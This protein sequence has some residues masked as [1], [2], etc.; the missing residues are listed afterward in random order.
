MSS[1][2]S[3]PQY[4]RSLAELEGDPT[5]QEY[6]ER[7]FRS[8]TEQKELDGKGR[9]RFMQLM[10]ASFALS[11]CYPAEKLAPDTKRADGVIPGVPRHFATVMDLA[12]AATGLMVK[13]F[14][15]RP[16]KVEGNPKDSQTGGGTGALHQ[17]SVLG[18]YD[19]DRSRQVQQA[20]KPSSYK[21]YSAALLAGF[22]KAKRN[23]GAGF[24][25]LSRA[26]SSPT[27]VSLRDKL[28]AEMPFAK[29]VTYE[30]L[31]TAGPREGA[32]LALSQPVTTLLNP[33]LADVIVA[34]DSDLLATHVTGGIGY[35]RAVASRRVADSGQMSRIYAFET[36]VTEIGSIAD[37]RVS[38]R[39]STVVAILAYLDAK[40]SAAKGEAGAQAAPAAEALGG[41]ASMSVLDAA[42]KDLL[43]AAGKGLLTVGTRH[44]AEAHALAHRLNVILGNA[45]AT[46][47]GE[48][49]PK[50]KKGEE[51]PLLPVSYLEPAPALFGGVDELAGLVAE[52]E[53]GH[54]QT[55]LILG[56]NPAYDAPV[57]VNFAG[58]LGKV[59][60]SFHL[61]LYQDETAALCS[62]HA[63]E[64]HYLEAWGDARSLDGSVRVAQPLI[65]PMLGGKS[66]I[67]ILAQ[68]LGLAATQGD[69]V[70]RSTHGLDV[71][72]AWRKAVHD[73]GFGKRGKV[74]TPELRSLSPVSLPKAEGLEVA[75][76]PSPSLF[77]GRF[78]NNAWL[79]ELPHPL[80][81]LC[82]GNAALVSPTTAREHGIKDGYLATV[83][84]EG[85]S[86]AMPALIAPAQADGVVTLSLGYGRKSAGVVGGYTSGDAEVV[87]AN[88]YRL[89][90]A[91]A[92]F[93]VF[94]GSIATTGPRQDVA[95]TQDLWAID[96]IGKQG[97]SDREDILV[98]ESTLSAYQ[99]HPDAIEHAVHHPKL[100]SLWN[101]PL[102]YEG[103]KWGLAIDLNKCTGC[104][105][106]MVACQAENNVPVVGKNEV[107]RG[108]EMT[109]IRVERYYKGDENAATVRQQPV[110]CQHCENAPCEQVCPVGATMHSPEGLNDMVYNRCIG[111]R[112]CSNNCPYKVRRFNYRNYNLDTI[113][114][115]PYTPTK[116]AN[117]KL[118]AM[119]FNPDVTVRGRGVM[120][121][122]T[123]CVQRIQE[124][125]IQS[126]NA[127]RPIVDGEIKVACEQACPTG[128]IVFGDLNDK[129]SRVASAHQV[130]RAY[131]L[132]QELNN[133]P[134]VNYLARISNPHPDLEPAHHA[135]A[136]AAHGADP[137]PSSTSPAPGTKTHDVHSEQH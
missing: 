91:K 80:S 52:M 115:T 78:A 127:Q 96:P 68:L 79:Q 84:V 38:V 71:E 6:V 125:K 67:E 22:A 93:L 110:M 59:K 135:A 50:A 104:A 15:G 4:W 64:A 136:G 86:L 56:A 107:A 108:R 70:V 90:V 121:K 85:R 118:K 1:M 105:T 114:L 12:G 30:A 35:G 99:K 88:T 45:R 65:E 11:G 76:E 10:G 75:F 19:P 14:D 53:G 24:F 98:R 60:E 63:P 106:C 130:P 25:V 94:G 20:G 18:L 82:W 132:L 72:K 39:P 122:C 111:T 69:A 103:H 131:E 33:E 42:V 134:R 8:P 83:T 66:A 43:A 48:K 123:F 16:I 128:A 100:L 3:R 62:W 101:S 26:S 29:W 54:V 28:I 89:R 44:G 133:R 7:E 97:Q 2:K 46:R 102:S 113:G 49:A 21:Q 47:S 116:D 81:K 120:E 119:V 51:L 5:F 32:K 55:L 37:H 13:S 124:V 126:K 23:S 41:A 58:A 9:R 40:I 57:D 34:V 87:G 31:D 95:I 92:P 137:H 27:L 61:G 112:Y 36:S 109:W 73:G 77:D 129:K 17:A 74:I 117:A